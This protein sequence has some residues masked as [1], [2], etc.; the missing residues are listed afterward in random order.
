MSSTHLYHTSVYFDSC[1]NSLLSQQLYES[2]SIFSLTCFDSLIK[3]D[4]STD[5]LLKIWCSEKNFSVK[6]SVFLI[7]LTGKFIWS[8]SL[9]ESSSGL[10]SCENTL[11][12][13][14]DCFCC[15]HEFSLEWAA[16]MLLFI[17]RDTSWWNLLFLSASGSQSLYFNHN[18]NSIL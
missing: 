10:I 15:S 12:W 8:E 3:H 13:S 5:V 18:T 2:F 4:N 17:F 14:T 7:V 9:T 16:C 6:S 11:A 1:M